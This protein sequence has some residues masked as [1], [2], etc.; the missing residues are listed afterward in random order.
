MYS[1]LPRSG[2]KKATTKGVSQQITRRVL[3]HEDYKNCLMNNDDM[4]HV[5][6][7]IRHNHHTLE[8]S[9]MLKKYLSPF[10]DKK[11]IVKKGDDFT[12]YSFGHRDIPGEV[13]IIIIII[14]K[15]VNFRC[16]GS[17]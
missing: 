9:T 16:G 4:Y 3:K 13:K 10:N 15:Y 7:N 14:M 8:T 6:V 1:I 17:R 11:W 5:M 12:T 2:L